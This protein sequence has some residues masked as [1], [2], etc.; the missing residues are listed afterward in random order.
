[1]FSA[2]FFIP[3]L[4]ADDSGLEGEFLLDLLAVLAYVDSKYCSYFHLCHVRLFQ[5]SRN[6]YFLEN[7][8]PLQI[9]VV[10][11]AAVGDFLME[12][13]AEDCSRDSVAVVDYS[14]CSNRCKIPNEIVSV[15]S[16]MN[17]KSQ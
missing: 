14:H 12:E 11:V 17:F 7:F 1:L 9:V 2:R 5:R 6:D 8:L 16:A 13:F 10:V 15:L 3:F 4:V